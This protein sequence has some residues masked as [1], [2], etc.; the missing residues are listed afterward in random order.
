[1]PI[2]PKTPKKSLLKSSM[3]NKILA[4]S[5][6]VHQSDSDQDVESPVR[7]NS[8]HSSTKS[9]IK[10]VTQFSRRNSSHKDD[11]E[12]EED[13]IQSLSRRSSI[14]S[15]TKSKIKAVSQFS[16]F[17]KERCHEFIY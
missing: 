4:A 5:K 17:N 1:M 12:L 14:K 6:F 7:R 16:K 13:Y 9:K 10:A 3:R 2:A 11:S 15:L 8:L